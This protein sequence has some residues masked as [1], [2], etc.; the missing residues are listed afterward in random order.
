M[1]K[2]R[3]LQIRVVKKSDSPAAD[4]T[5]P[6]PVVDAD[7]LNDILQVVTYHAVPVAKAV[8]G[9]YVARKLLNTACEIAVIAATAKLK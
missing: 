3:A 8:A 2:N 1:L 7:T 5:N 6:T 4:D 9:A